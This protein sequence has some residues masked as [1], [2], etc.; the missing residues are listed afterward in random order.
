TYHDLTAHPWAGAA[1]VLTLQAE[2]DTGQIGTSDAIEFVLP[3]RPFVKP[4]ARAIVEQR[5]N[6]VLNPTKRVAIIRA[7]DALTIAPDK[8]V[9]D[10]NIY[11]AIRTA[12]WRLEF[13]QDREALLS[14]VD[15]LW[16]VALHIEDG[17]LSDAEQE[18]RAAQEALQRALAEN[19][20]PEEIRELMQNLRS[21]LDRYM[22]ALAES[23]RSAEQN[24][25][26]Q[27]DSEQQTISQ[28]DLNRMLD[29]I[30][31]MARNG[32]QDQAQ[33]LLSQL[34][35]ILENLRAGQS[36]AQNPQQKM[37]SQSLEQLGEL[38]NRQRQLMDETFRYDQQQNDG[39]RRP[40]EDGSNAELDQL[41]QEQ[42]ELQAMLDQ[43]MDQM[44]QFNMPPNDNFD[45]AKGNMGDAIN[46][47]GQGET[48][49]AASNQG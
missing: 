49:P 15:Q 39:E 32:A 38:M 44:Q 13:A 48:G 26:L 41:R 40:S 17:D 6:L 35:D 1:V 5:R 47:L 2:D 11:L 14:V 28:D 20:P 25:E 43:L 27:N 37:M 8:Y 46:S 7:L 42:A 9:E 36:Q 19:A 22:Q 45:D 3:S 23:A 12:R 24:A 10:L 30:E 4:L 34:Q 21:A 18:L 33:Q 31:N 29:N 16:Q